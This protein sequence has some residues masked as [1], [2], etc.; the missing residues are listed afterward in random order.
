ML[1]QRGIRFGRSRARHV[2]ERGGLL[3]VSSAGAAT[4]KL[5][6]SAIVGLTMVDDMERNLVFTHSFCLPS[7]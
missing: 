7:A 1:S 2:I 3:K 4:L 6:N 5:Y